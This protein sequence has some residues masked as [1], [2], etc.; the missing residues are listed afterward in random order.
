M[1]GGRYHKRFTAET[2]AFMDADHDAPVT[3]GHTPLRSAARIV[4]EEHYRR[5]S[6]YTHARRAYADLCAIFPDATAETL[7]TAMLR[8]WIAVMESRGNKA[9][10]INAAL[11]TIGVMFKHLDI[12]EPCRVPYVRKAKALKWW[13]TPELEEQA[14]AWMSEKGYRDLR[15]FMQYITRTGLRVE[16][17][18]RCQRYHFTGL[19]SDR[20]TL[21]VPGT[22][23]VAAQA[24]IPL[25]AE[26]ATLAL[27][28]L[29]HTGDADD[30]LFPGTRVYRTR[31]GHNGGPQSLRYQTLQ[32][33]WLECRRALGITNPTATLKALRR[34]FARRMS[35]RGAP[36]EIVQ[37]VLRHELIATTMEYLRLT[38]G[39]DVERM[40]QWMR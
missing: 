40:R 30:F 21:S 12:P 39:S 19:A 34:S 38:G 2:V 13:L 10:T 32:G 7:T 31:R 8:R 24:A 23:T 26:A 25:L 27:S 5:T 36:T 28:R 14:A 15:D 20:P 17:A 4:L 9:S 1:S 22:K 29:G 16:E 3:D 11:A 33:Q 35:D 18:L 6:R 37:K